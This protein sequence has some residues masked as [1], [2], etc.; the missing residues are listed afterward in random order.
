LAAQFVRPLQQAQATDRSARSVWKD[1]AVPGPVKSILRRSCADCHSL[2]TNWPWYAQIA[3]ASWVVARDVRHAREHMNLS[4]WPEAPDIEEA[5]I[6][7]MVSASKMPPRRY[8]LMHPGARLSEAER[9][10][11]LKWVQGAGK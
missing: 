11:I 1:P 8:T 4:V 3:P 10:V 5:E 9:Q 2:E 6:A 7:D